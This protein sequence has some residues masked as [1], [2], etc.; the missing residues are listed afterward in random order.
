MISLSLNSDVS[1]MV[2]ILNKTRQQ[3]PFAASQAVNDTAFALRLEYGRATEK[4][5]D[6][7]TPATKRGWRVEKSN[8]RQRPIRAQVMAVSHTAP[9]LRRQI[10]RSGPQA[11]VIPRS[12]RINR[13]GN[14]PRNYVK[15]RRLKAGFF[16]GQP[17]NN[18]HLPPGLYQRV[19][20]GLSNR[21]GV[22]LKMHVEFDKSVEHDPQ[23]PFRRIG[24]QFVR[25]NLEKNFFRRYRQAVR[26]MRV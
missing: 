18:P 4:Y 25:R 23:F 16:V 15:G 1:R 24:V 5:F 14:L 8:K 2:A 13:Y 17:R 19:G 3:I 20:A 12:A 21:A 7:P 11:R 9:Y 10:V 26:T 22:K 6:R